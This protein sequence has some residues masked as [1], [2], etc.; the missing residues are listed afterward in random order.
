MSPFI[1]ESHQSPAR[2]GSCVGGLRKVRPGSGPHV[3]T[4]STGAAGPAPSVGGLRK[5]RAGC[6][7]HVVFHSTSGGAGTF[8]GW[9]ETR[10][11]PAAYGKPRFIPDA[12]KSKIQEQPDRLECLGVL[13]PRLDAAEVGARPC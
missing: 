3:A 13:D 1:P 6:V 5:V 11:G 12:P 2:P 10:R 8:G 9:P 4:H 7:Q